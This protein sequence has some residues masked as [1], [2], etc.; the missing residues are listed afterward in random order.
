MDLV[1]DYAS[2]LPITV[3]AEILGAP[4][5]MREQFLR[6]GEGVA[7][8]ADPGVTY[9]DYRRVGRAQAPRQGGVGG[10]I[11]H[12]PPAPDPASRS[13]HGRVG[14]PFVHSAARATWMGWSRAKVGAR[15]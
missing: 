1:T 8:S 6:W 15:T 3:I 4:V 2:L 13:T 11:A 9:R 10:P 7:L 14:R 12:R 5:A